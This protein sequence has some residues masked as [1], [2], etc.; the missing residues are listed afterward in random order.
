MLKVNDKV[1]FVNCGSFYSSKT[2]FSL[3][4]VTKVN[5]K[6]FRISSESSAVGDVLY[7]N[8]PRGDFFKPQ[9]YKRNNNYCV[10]PF[11]QEKWDELVEKDRERK[12]D[13]EEKRTIQEQERKEW[14][15]REQRDI[16]AT[17]EAFG[18]PTLNY[19]KR[20]FEKRINWREFTGGQ[21]V[22]TVDMPIRP[23]LSQFKLWEIVIIKM[24][25]RKS[26]DHQGGYSKDVIECFYTVTNNKTSSFGS[27]SVN[28]YDTQEEALWRTLSYFYMQMNI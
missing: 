6:T 10:Y 3:E 24:Q 26:W 7:S 5:K 16:N 20:G 21:V 22:V 8:E 11:T 12:K 19:I 14:E 25:P 23:E 15:E 13:Q 4:R 18:N 28:T 9:E 2:I 17:K 1:I 27:Y